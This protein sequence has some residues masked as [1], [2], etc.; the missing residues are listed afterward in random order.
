VAAIDRGVTPEQI[1]AIVHEAGARLRGFIRRHVP[2]GVDADD[3]VQDV[4]VK[5]LQHREQI[6]PQRLQPWIFQTA[7][8]AIVDAHRR[9]AKPLVTDGIELVSHES[10]ASAAQELADCMRPLL[11]LLDAEDRLLLERIEMQGGSQAELSR[12]LNLAA[13]TVKS[14][15]QRARKKLRTR[16]D[17]CCRVEL[18]ARGLPTAH[19]PRSAEG[20]TLCDTGRSALQD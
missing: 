11:A 17:Q 13:S 15:V 7:R 19:E 3:V 14:R 2:A 20:C 4:L 6:D 16:L 9:R 12:E 18:D 1:D 8:N 10:E 5:L